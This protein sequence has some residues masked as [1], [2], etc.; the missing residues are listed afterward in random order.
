MKSSEVLKEMI[1]WLTRRIKELP[2]EKS[3]YYKDMRLTLKWE[4]K[5]ILERENENLA[6][7][8]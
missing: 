2:E 7:N 1:D 8:Y 5:T 3:V 6:T 4:L